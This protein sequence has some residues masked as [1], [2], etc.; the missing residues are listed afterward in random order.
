MILCWFTK[1]YAFCRLFIKK[2]KKKYLFI[3]LD[4]VKK[5]LCERC[6]A[7]HQHIIN[8]FNNDPFTLQIGNCES[9]NAL[10]N[11][12]TIYTFFAGASEIKKH[13]YSFFSVFRSFFLVLIFVDAFLLITYCECLICY[14]VKIHEA[15][16]R[17]VGCFQ[18]FCGF[19]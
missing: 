18:A 7:V 5:K 12:S 9:C 10:P 11:F 13:I 15:F 6:H 19:H 14:W 4:D 16:N 17:F 3:V 8:N 1:K 2:K